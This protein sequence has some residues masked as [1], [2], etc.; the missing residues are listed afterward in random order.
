MIKKPL[1]C[2]NLYKY[3][4]ISDEFKNTESLIR[5]SIIRLNSPVEFNDPF[6]LQIIPRADIHDADLKNWIELQIQNPLNEAH[7]NKLIQFLESGDFKI[8]HFRNGII[9]GMLE[10]GIKTHGVYCFSRLWD[11][12]LMWSHY[13]N[14]HK[15][16]CV[17]FKISEDSPVSAYLTDVIY[18]DRYPH[19]YINNSED[20]KLFFMTKYLTWKY[21]G[22]VRIIK[23]RACGQFIQLNENEV[24]AIIFGIKATEMEIDK[25]LDWVKH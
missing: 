2:V 24:E 13:A 16:I 8:E 7:K 17:C 21:E 12:I 4:T 1:R 6:D 19:V 10:A 23:P 18:A 5:N 14:K 9:E 3:C 11:S 15:G 25:V 22:E 20:Y